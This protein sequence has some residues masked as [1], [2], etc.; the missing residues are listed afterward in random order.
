MLSNLCTGRKSLYDRLA[1][2]TLSS[3]REAAWKNMEIDD[4]TRAVSG[5]KLVQKLQPESI[6]E[7]AAAYGFVTKQF[8]RFN[9]GVPVTCLEL[10]SPFCSELR[11]QGYEVI[12]ADFLEEDL[13]NRTWDVVTAMQVLEHLSDREALHAALLRLSSWARR[14]LFIEIPE[15]G[16]LDGE[17]H[18]LAL[19]S[20]EL[21]RTM[22]GIGLKL[23]K[24]LRIPPAGRQMGNGYTCMVQIVGGKVS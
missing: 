9:P 24:I 7:V 20:E 3:G 8:S 21:V 16:L 5:A 13:G 18:I 1:E 11:A 14:Y 19:T 15:G 23:S 4:L 6:L 22:E 2:E 10:A 12:E 17:R